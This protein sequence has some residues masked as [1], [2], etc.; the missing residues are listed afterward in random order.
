MDERHRN[1]PTIPTETTRRQLL[2]ALTASLLALLGL[3]VT[4]SQSAAKRKNKDK[5]S[6]KL[7]PL[8]RRR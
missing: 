5:K 3:G 1:E 2:T 8:P 4:T 7:V 6:A